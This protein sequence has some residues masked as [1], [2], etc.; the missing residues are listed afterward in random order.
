MAKKKDT[1]EPLP[2]TEAP[3]TEPTDNQQLATATL[4]S[5]SVFEC[6]RP[7]VGVQSIPDQDWNK[8]LDKQNGIVI[9]K[10]GN[11]FV[12]LKEL[13]RLARIKGLK[14]VSTF[15]AQ[16][17]NPENKYTSCVTVD[18]VFKDGTGFSG[19][20]EAFSE[21][22]DENFS[23]YPTAIA[24]S[25]ALARALRLGLG[26]TMCSVEEVSQ[27][28]IDGTAIFNPDSKISVSQKNCIT[29]LCE[30]EK[31]SLDKVLGLGTRA[32][33]SIDD[34]TVKEARDLI[35]YLNNNKKELSKLK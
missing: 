5:A 22:T 9:T 34:L 15:I 19:A 20:A 12:L 35:S 28:V 32:V 30:R 14:Q 21:N 16:S 2:A 29:T 10:N 8:L 6:G 3:A 4:N 18:V 25:R 23:L 26:I 33:S 13:L 1:M 17:P 11:E 7:H 24:E 27:K 31:V